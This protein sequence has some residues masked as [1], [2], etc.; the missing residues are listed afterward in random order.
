MEGVAF[1][2]FPEDQD[3]GIIMENVLLQALPIL[4]IEDRVMEAAEVPEDQELPM[5]EMGELLEE[6]MAS[7]AALADMEVDVTEVTV[8]VAVATGE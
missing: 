1:Q 8:V 5:V 3:I 4:T 2:G 6:A 7:T